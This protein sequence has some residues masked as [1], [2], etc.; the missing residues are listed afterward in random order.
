MPPPGKAWG[1]FLHVCPPGLKTRSALQKDTQG[2]ARGAHS[3]QDPHAVE[4]R[5]SAESLEVA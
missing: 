1:L 4:E 2:G 3:H 5:T